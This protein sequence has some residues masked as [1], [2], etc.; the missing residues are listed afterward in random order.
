MS[1]QRLSKPPR[2]RMC[3]C[4]VSTEQ[5][6]YPQIGRPSARRGVTP[7]P[8]GT[9]PCRLLW[10]STSSCWATA[11][12]SGLRVVPGRV[13]PLAPVLAGPARAPGEFRIQVLVAPI[14]H[15]DDVFRVISRKHLQLS[16]GFRRGG[17]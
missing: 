3:A 9:L 11:P 7:S 12:V 6:G 8:F 2:Q 13:A 17:P 14:F 16:R 4:N 10:V 1:L 5:C 15:T